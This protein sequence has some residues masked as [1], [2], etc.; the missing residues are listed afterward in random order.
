MYCELHLCVR[1]MQWRTSTYNDVQWRATACS[2]VSW[3]KWRKQWRTRRT[4]TCDGVDDGQWRTVW[5]TT[6][7]TNVHRRTVK[8]DD[9]KTVHWSTLTC[10]DVM[11]RTM[12]Y[13]DIQTY[14][15]HILHV[16]ARSQSMKLATMLQLVRGLRIADPKL[17]DLNH[18]L[19]R[20]YNRSQQRH[21]L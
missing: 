2:G 16:T 10:N 3:R 15:A 7:C 5:R 6:I 13:T 1:C 8:R 9:V 20:R 17:N 18:R 21:L 19:A 4:M 14:K 12:T 11:L